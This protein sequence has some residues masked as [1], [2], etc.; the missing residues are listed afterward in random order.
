MAPKQAST[1]EA[2]HP[3]GLVKP[4]VKRQLHPLLQKPIPHAYAL[5][6]CPS[7]PGLYYAVHLAHVQAEQLDHLEPNSRPL[8]APFGLIRISAAMEKRHQQKLWGEDK[9]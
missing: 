7:R 9:G 4:G 1:A 6:P 8:Q 2:V 5:V 3:D